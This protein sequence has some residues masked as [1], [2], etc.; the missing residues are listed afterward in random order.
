MFRQIKG[1]DHALHILQAAIQNHRIAQAYLFHGPVGVGKFTTALYFGM[2]LNCLSSSEFRPC[3]VCASCRKF[4]ALDHPDLIYIFPTPNLKSNADGEYQKKEAQD[5][6]EAFLKNK[7]ETPWEVFRFNSS[8]LIRKESMSMLIKRLELSIFEGPYRICIIE[9]AD[10]MN[11]ATA[12]AFL[13]TL[14]E[15]PRNTIVVLVT[16][17]LSM[18]LPTIISRCQPVYFKPLTRGVLESILVDKHECDTATARVASRIAGGN[19]KK[20][21]QI[22]AGSTGEL[23]NLAFEITDLAI[24][25]RELDFHFLIGRIKE[26]INAESLTELIGYICFIVSD[27]VVY[28]SNPEDVTNVDRLDILAAISPHEELADAALEFLVQAEDLKRKLDGNVNANLVLINLFMRLRALLI[29]FR[30]M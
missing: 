1:Q 5:Q 3:G 29:R 12:N 24:H 20:A 2:A 17:R 10:E 18:M 8:T 28:H 6:Y 21:I 9:D 4:L 23:R 7:V 27:M 26:Y 25:D 15:P 30:E 16:T 14:E 11:T 22:A 19:L 13:K